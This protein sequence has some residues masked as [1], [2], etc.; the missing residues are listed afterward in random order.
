MRQGREPL[1][2]FGDLKQFFDTAAPTPE[3]DRDSGPADVTAHRPTHDD[4]R[5]PERPGPSDAAT[6]AADGPVAG[7]AIGA[8]RAGHPEPHGQESPPTA[9]S[10]DRSGT[11]AADGDRPPP[12]S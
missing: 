6:T 2:T 1:R 7:G 4:D 9:E 10:G 3:A 12:A 5:Q 8:L 11:E